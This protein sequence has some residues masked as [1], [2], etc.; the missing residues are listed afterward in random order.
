MK[1]VIFIAL[2]ALVICNLTFV[3]APSAQ[4]A[5][6]KYLAQHWITGQVV[7]APDGTQVILYMAANPSI[8]TTGTTLGGKYRINAYTLGWRDGPTWRII[9]D[10]SG[11]PRAEVRDLT[12]TGGSAGPVGLAPGEPSPRFSSGKGVESMADMTYSGIRDIAYGPQIKASALFQ[13]FAS[14]STWSHAQPC[15]VRVEAREVPSGTDIA[16]NATRLVA[17]ADVILNSEGNTTGRNGFLKPD[18]T[19]F[20]AATPWTGGG[21]Y[22]AIKQKSTDTLIG[23]PHLSVI[24]QRKISMRNVAGDRDA[25]TTSLDLTNNPSVTDAPGA[26]GSYK[27]TPYKPAP[28]KPDALAANSGRTLFRAG[29]MDGNKIIDVIDTS[30]W[31]RLYN[32]FNAGGTDDPADPYARANLD[33]NMGADGRPI[34]DVID[35]SWWYGTFSELASDPGPHGYVPD[36][37]P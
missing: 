10:P 6:R 32:R 11:E 21:Y 35:T 8:T 2:A 20:G 3:I 23:I 14:T 29:D 5:P 12:G 36:I 19:E 18:G 26:G 33:R 37:V 9:N 16:G 4:A 34:I 22:L 7:G 30:H 15:V 28:T 13:A 24:T 27:E 1:K 31:T 17:Y 25:S